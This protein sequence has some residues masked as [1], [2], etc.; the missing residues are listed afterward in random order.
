MLHTME[1]HEITPAHSLR[2]RLLPNGAMRTDLDHDHG[3]AASWSVLRCYRHGL[4]SHCLIRAEIDR[5]TYF[6]SVPADPLGSLD[7]AN[8]LP[9][10]VERFGRV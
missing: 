9:V 7:G 6:A 10:L 3:V 4:Q 2:V 1:M 5:R 8:G